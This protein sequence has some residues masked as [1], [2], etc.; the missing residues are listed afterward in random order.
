M[1]R[2][3]LEELYRLNSEPPVQVYA[4][5]IVGAERTLLLGYTCD[6]DTWHVYFKDDLLHLHIYEQRATGPRLVEHFKQEAFPATELIPDKRVYPEY[7]D[8]AFALYLRRHDIAVPYTRFDA[9]RYA[10]TRDRFFHG[11]VKD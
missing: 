1:N 2:D 8:F 9:F 7:T 6:R 3:Q 10:E 4:G 5:Q 11:A